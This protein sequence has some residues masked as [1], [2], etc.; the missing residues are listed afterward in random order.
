MR[1]SWNVDAKW[2]FGLACLAA[3]IVAGG[4]YSA[5]KVTE[6]DPATGIFTGVMTTFA[7]ESDG[8]EGFAEIQALA[9]ANPDQEFTVEGVTLPVK[10]SEL[11]GL[12]Y[13][14][15]VEL[16]VGRISDMLYVDGPGSVEQFFQDVSAAD[17]EGAPAADSGGTDLGPFGLLTQDSHDTIRSIFTYSL[18]PI[19]VF[20]FPLLFFSH[21]FGHLGSLGVVLAAG[22]AP[23]ALLWLV[24]KQATKNPG[25]DGIGTALSEAL[26]P[27][28]GELS[29]TFLALLAVGVGLILAAV[30]GHIGFAVWEHRQARRAPAAE[31]VPPSGEPGEQPDDPPGDEPSSPSGGFSSFGPSSLPQR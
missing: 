21:R 12:S 6:R 7:K 22:T 25:E 30:L 13:D 18:I 23:F 29:S 4:L 20:A 15:A 16:V 11:A 31:E 24:V 17:P 5:A 28:A 2:V 26:S 3:V 14:E 1:K 27:S 19:L 9:A 10:G 8:S